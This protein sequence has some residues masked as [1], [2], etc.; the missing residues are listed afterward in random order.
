MIERR[1]KGVISGRMG[2]WK[3]VVVKGARQV[4]KT[5]LQWQY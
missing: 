3:A 1:L 5:A 4:G 2:D